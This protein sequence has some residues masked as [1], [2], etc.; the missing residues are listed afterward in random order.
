[1]EKVFSKYPSLCVSLAGVM[2]G[3]ISIFVKGLG[4]AGLSSLDIMLVRSVLAVVGIFLYLALFDREKLRIKL[5]DWWIFFGTGVISFFTFGVSYFI[6]IEKT[7]A[8]VA[9]VLLYTSPVFVMIMAALF[10]KEKI[11]AAK[12]VA[13]VIA[14]CGCVFV[15]GGFGGGGVSPSGLATGLLSGF[16]YALYSIFGRIA[17]KKYSPITVTAYTFLFASVACLFTADVGTVGALVSEKPSLLPTMAAM[18]VI[19]AIFP[20]ILYTGGLKNIP[21]GKA[22]VMACVEPAVAF[23]TGVTVFGEGITPQSLV[24]TAMIF[25]AI[26]ILNKSPK[27]SAKG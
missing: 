17:A 18:A 2:W 3:I 22:A 23:L 16:T 15:S 5:C 19:T 9:A 13:T 27:I 14:V 4:M 7:S 21:A 26:I 12:I 25:A 24:G 10:F 1:M 8:S 11:T 20:Y 6:T